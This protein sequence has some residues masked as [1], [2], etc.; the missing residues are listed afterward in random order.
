MK[1][2]EDLHHGYERITKENLMQFA[3]RDHGQSDLFDTDFVLDSIPG[4]VI[5]CKCKEADAPEILSG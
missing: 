1:K 4:A 3:R 2:G 5:V